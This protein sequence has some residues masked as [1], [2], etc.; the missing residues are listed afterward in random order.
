[1]TRKKKIIVFGGLAA[2]VLALIAFNAA[3]QRDRGV[4][5]RLGEVERRDLVATVTASGQIEPK[6]S[7]DISADI[8]GRIIE[9]PVE[10]GDLVERGQLLLRID[11]SQYEAAVARARALEASSQA[12]LLQARAN[13]D[14]AR[15]ALDR[16]REL[17]RQDPNLVSDEQLEQSQTSFDVA[18]AMAVSAGHQV[19]QAQA[20]LQEAREALAKTVLRSPM[21]GEVTRLAKEEGEVAVPGTFSPETGLLLTV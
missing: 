11:P 14:Q 16:A 15:R 21:A 3:A 1:M 13:R 5:V 9:I 2:V 8:T 7:V 6:Q 19:A 17:K 4:S 12:S 10:E 20:G 18:E